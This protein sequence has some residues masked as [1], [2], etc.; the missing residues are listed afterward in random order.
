MFGS[1]GSEWGDLKVSNCYNICEVV[2]NY[3]ADKTVE[4]SIYFGNI[5]G[6]VF[7]NIIIENCYGYT[8]KTINLPENACG[9]GQNIGAIQHNNQGAYEGTKVL[10][11][12]INKNDE[13]PSVDY[14]SE[15]ITQNVQEV[16]TYQSQ[17]F[18]DMLNDWV[19]SNNPDGKY[20]KWKYDAN[21]NGGCP[22]LESLEGTIE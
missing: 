12:Y 16:E 13:Y 8:N 14:K 6:S 17:E 4:R 18:C 10:T 2:L 11:G 9:F 15:Y 22:Y 1:S 7:E 20:S 19:N 21:K 5:F 3:P